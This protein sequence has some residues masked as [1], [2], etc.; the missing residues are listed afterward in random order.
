[1]SMRRIRSVRISC[2]AMVVEEDQGKYY[3]NHIA[4]VQWHDG[5]IRWRSFC[6]ESA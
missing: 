6:E 2:K 4:M 5:F 1:M 3:W